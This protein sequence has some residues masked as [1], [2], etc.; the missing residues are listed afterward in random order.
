MT[1]SKFYYTLISLSLILSMNLV[2]QDDSAST[3]PA[4]DCWCMHQNLGSGGSSLSIR[5]VDSLSINA[6]PN[7]PYWRL[8]EECADGEDCE[9]SQCKYERKTCRNV[10][11]E[12]ICTWHPHTGE[13]N[14][15]DLG[16]GDI[17]WDT[18]G[19]TPSDEC[20]CISIP[21]PSDISQVYFNI[22]DMQ[23]KYPDRYI[24]MEECSDE[25]CEGSCQYL[26]LSGSNP[27]LYEGFCT[28]YW[29]EDTIISSPPITYRSLNLV[30]EDRLFLF[31][32]PASSQVILKLVK[33]EDALVKVE[34]TDLNG[35]IVSRVESM[36]SQIN[37]SLEELPRGFYIVQARI[38]D[39]RIRER[40]VVE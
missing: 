32:N 33:S 1:T 28:E 9:S 27:G 11:G 22:N 26:K 36:D 18:T 38:G 31:P 40:L 14:I 16:G 21:N 34:I 35:R 25:D 17:P 15:G 23:E 20:N 2:G 7:D 30:Y 19:V 4:D 5:N 8:I 3:A 13:C 29:P 10:G 39:I 6:N 37:I 12:R 24:I